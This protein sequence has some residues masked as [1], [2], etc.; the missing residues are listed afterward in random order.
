MENVKR[1]KNQRKDLES[2]R[3][4]NKKIKREEDEGGSTIERIDQNTEPRNVKTG[5]VQKPSEWNEVTQY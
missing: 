1:W 5:R 4:S 3:K 2:K